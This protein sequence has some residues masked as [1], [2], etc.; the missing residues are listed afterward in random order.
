MFE[1]DLEV[2]VVK[3]GDKIYSFKIDDFCCYC[4]F[5]GLDS[6]GLMLQYEVVIFDYEC[7]LLVFMN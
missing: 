4:M 3:V 6:I 1:V 5:N 7:K 2:Q